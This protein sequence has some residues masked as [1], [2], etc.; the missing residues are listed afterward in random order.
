M[1]I[2]RNEWKLKHVPWSGSITLQKH[3]PESQGKK[4]DVFLK[5]PNQCDVSKKSLKEMHKSKWWK[6]S[7]QL[8]FSL[9]HE[10]KKSLKSSQ[11]WKWIEPYGE[12]I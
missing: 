6:S 12:T 10:I 11:K 4:N 7:H 8:S 9:F 5:I 1:W 2:G 3:N